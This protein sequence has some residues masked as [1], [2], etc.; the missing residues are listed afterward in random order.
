MDAYLIDGVEDIN[1]D[2]FNK[3]EAI[4]VTAGASAPEVLVEEVIS[5]LQKLFGATVTTNEKATENVRFQ[6]PKELR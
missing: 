2:W 1:Y 6:L 4:G 5:S 3:A